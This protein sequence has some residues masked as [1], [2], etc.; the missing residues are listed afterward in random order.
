MAETFDSIM[1]GLLAQ[2]GIRIGAD[3]RLELF[4]GFSGAGAPSQETIDYVNDVQQ[5]RR[6]HPKLVLSWV[7]DF[8]RTIERIRAGDSTDPADVRASFFLRLHGIIVDI[9]RQNPIAREFLTQGPPTPT[10]LLHKLAMVLDA[11]DK[12]RG[13]LDENEQ[14][15]A[16]YRRHVYAHVYQF[17][18]EPQWN[19]KKD[20]PKEYLTSKYTGQSYEIHEL[21]NRL[22]SVIAGY[23]T[24]AVIAED[25][26][27]RMEAPAK[28]LMTAIEAFCT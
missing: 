20:S 23:A 18:Y 17:G 28:E 6:V 14:L 13:Q 3:G 21:E 8:L 12:V 27:R 15:Y 4:P 24:E 22:A 7:S 2:K 11:I 9:A 10:S 19:K 1:A 25:F 5:F 26:A 16:E